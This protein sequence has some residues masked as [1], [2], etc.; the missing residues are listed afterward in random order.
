MHTLDL[1]REVF[2][3]V[4]REKIPYSL[5]GIRIRRVSM[6]VS[7][8]AEA[9]PVIQVSEPKVIAMTPEAMKTDLLGRAEKLGQRVRGLPENA[10]SSRFWEPR[11]EEAFSG[12]QE[13]NRNN[14]SA[15]D[16]IQKAEA[17][18]HLL[19]VSTKWPLVEETQKP[20]VVGLESSLRRISGRHPLR[21]FRG[22]EGRK[23]TL[24]AA[25]NE[26]ESFQLVL[27]PLTQALRNVRFEVADLK[28]SEGRIISSDNITVYLQIE[29]KVRPSPGTS[30]EWAGWLPDALLPLD[31]T[32]N[33]EASE[34]R[35]LLITVYIPLGTPAG[36]YRSQVRVLPEGLPSEAVEVQVVVRDFDIPTVGRFRTQG[37]FSMEDL[38]SWYGDSYSGE[39]RRAFYRLLLEHRLTP[40]SQYSARLSPEREDITWIL[41]RGGNVLVIG[42]FSGRP[43]DSSIIQPAYDWL[44]EKGHIDKAI[45]YI[46]DETDDFKEVRHKA[47]TIRQHW[48]KLRI[49][50]G[51]SKPRAELVDYVD[52][53]D[54]ITFGGEV[55]NFDTGSTRTAQN[56]GEEVFWYTC[57]GPKMPFANVYNDFPLTAIRAL[58]WQAWKYGITGYEYWWFNYWKPNIGLSQQKK[59]WPE[60]K[61]QDWNSRS[62]EWANGDGLLVYP[63]SNGNPL[64]SLRLSVIR[65]AIEDWEALFILQRGVELAGQTEPAEA[66]EVCRRARRLLEV[67]PKVTTSLTS[68]S[69]DA[70]VYLQARHELYELVDALVVILGREQLNQYVSDWGTR[71]QTWLQESFDERVQRVK[72]EVREK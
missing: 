42:G 13:F 9:S 34:T 57:V 38:K 62:F 37:H 7:P 58:W 66:E 5:A 35:P 59:P 23:V 29:Q 21:T 72:T 63:G 39:V 33:V 44:V 36:E 71:H 65:D 27:L 52:V 53:W 40:T 68:W 51:G 17:L 12:A 2:E 22:K 26:F 28:S 67:P 43:L 49:M 47:S 46:G 32:F 8:P 30:T 50:V 14:G 20:Y 69:R 56:R 24:E 60:W 45:I 11:V 1:N 48:P 25:R 15:A 3:S 61:R 18:E 70:E 41:E 54:P 64:P 16:W 10:P 31:G 4:T 6:E 19:L 55:Y